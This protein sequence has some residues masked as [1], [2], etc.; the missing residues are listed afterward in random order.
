M[1]CLALSACTMSNMTD[2]FK[3]HPKT[4][5]KTWKLHSS[6]SSDCFFAFFP[7]LVMLRW[8]YIWPTSWT[9]VFT[10][11]WSIAKIRFVT[12]TW[13]AS[14]LSVSLSW[15][16]F[17]S[18]FTAFGF[19]AQPV[20]LLQLGKLKTVSSLYQGKGWHQFERFST[21]PHNP[22]GEHFRN[23]TWHFRD[24]HIHFS[25]RTRKWAKIN[26]VMHI[27]TSWNAWMIRHTY[28]LEKAEAIFH[29]DFRLMQTDTKGILL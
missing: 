26:E 16:T 24:P 2:L 1:A 28:R 19:A 13:S 11:S 23:K 25:C 6:H 8:R 12:T 7:A 29:S 3:N 9:L 18:Y 27:G 17:Q 21:H 4:Q 20:T 5:S 14:C 15:K 22:Q 10:T